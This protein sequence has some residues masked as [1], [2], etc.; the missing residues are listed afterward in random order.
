MPRRVAAFDDDDRERTGPV[1]R[2]RRPLADVRSTTV[3]IV[4][5][6]AMWVGFQL[7]DDTPP[8][9]LD[10]ILVAVFGLWF[11]SEARRHSREHEEDKT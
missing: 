3:G 11:A 2:L 5:L 1:A 4:C 8:P 7:F 6:T 10:Q 9:V